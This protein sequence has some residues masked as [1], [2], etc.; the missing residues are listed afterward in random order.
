MSTANPVIE[1][2]IL[3]INFEVAKPFMKGAILR[4]NFKVTYN[5]WYF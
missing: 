3:R 2:A 1:Y 5:F 4:I